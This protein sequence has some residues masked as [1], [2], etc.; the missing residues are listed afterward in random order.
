MR[1]IQTGRVRREN[2]SVSFVLGGISV[3]SGTLTWFWVHTQGKLM[4][5]R[6]LFYAEGTLF[7]AC[8]ASVNIGGSPGG[9]I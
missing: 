1:P 4:H 9:P 8:I 2:R 3:A 6:R 7:D 5:S